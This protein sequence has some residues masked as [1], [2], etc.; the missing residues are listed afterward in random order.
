[1]I[2]QTMIFQWILAMSIMMAVSTSFW[3]AL[4]M[5]LEMNMMIFIPMMNSKNFL[6]SN[7]MVFY[8]IIQSLASSLFF[9]SSIM[10]PMFMTQNLNFIMIISMLIKLAAAP[11]HSWF[12]QISEG[13]NFFS[14][15]I[16]STFQ[17]IIP[18][19]II[20]LIN[21]NTLVPFIILSSIVGSLGGLSQTS[22][23]KILAFSSISHLSWIMTLIMINQNFWMIY[24]TIY[25]MILI[26]IIFWLKN[27]NSLHIINSNSMKMSFFN[28]M[29]LFSFFLSLGG[30]PPFLG[31]LAK[32][33][34]IIMISKKLPLILL[35]L[36]ISSLLNLFFYMR[37]MF[38]MIL[39]FNIQQ[40]TP[41]L[42][43]NY[44]SLSL[45]IINFMSITILTP[46]IISM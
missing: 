35:I 4:W 14:F 31:F 8:Y 11:F 39:N 25:T 16:L 12:P 19:H 37:T 27:N 3:F 23:K 43:Q 42:P 38:P 46:I 41:T 30:M 7:S 15:F 24:F 29:L 21:N 18:L 9:L 22:Y 10:S 20:T 13:M 32:W 28:K 36:I 2:L 26:M 33:V 1:M 17:K 34:A 40:K 44:Q 6:S 5:A 45:F